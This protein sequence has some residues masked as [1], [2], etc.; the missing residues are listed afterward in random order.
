MFS[1]KGAPLYYQAENYIREKI[2]K[3]E[4]EVGSQIPTEI[5][6]ME[7]FGISR[8]TLRQAISD[9]VNEGFLERQQGR[10]TFVKSNL[11]SKSNPTDIWANRIPGEYHQPISTEV[12]R[13]PERINHLL[14]RPKDGEN[15]KITY[16]HCMQNNAP[17][18]LSITYFPSEKFPDIGEHM[19]TDSVYNV[20][21]DI[22][23]IFCKNAMSN[24]RAIM[25]PAEYAKMLNLK[26]GIPAIQIE[27]IYYDVSDAPIILTELY[28][29]PHNFDMKI[30]TQL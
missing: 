1:K 12:V 5:Q 30:E 22:Y 15:I 10:G 29:H 27:K 16:L 25:L 23:G 8:A 28:L 6:L 14:G 18:N 19:F 13:G 26:P 4:W 17:F 3:N 9:L 2:L 7:T 21:K 11:I 24:V 20:L